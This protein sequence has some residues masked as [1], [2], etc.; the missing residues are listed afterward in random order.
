MRALMRPVSAVAASSPIET[1][2][3]FFSITT[4]AYFHVLSAIKYSPFFAPDAPLPPR[5]AHALLRDNEW[6]GVKHSTWRDAAA[7]PEGDVAALELQQ[8]V[9]SLDTNAAKR[10]TDKFSQDASMVHGSLANWTRYLTH[11]FPTTSGNVY[12]NLCYHPT[13]G[14]TPETSTPCFTSIFAESPKSD[15]LTL[16]FAPGARD[17]FMA[18]FKKE[19][20]FASEQFGSVKYVIEQAE[21]ES[22]EEMKSGKWMAYAA[23]T[24]VMRF[25]DLAKKAD[26][27]DIVLILAGYILMHTTFIK[28]FLASR[29][30]G[31]NLWLTTAILASSVLAFMVSLPIA[32]YL[33]IPLEPVSLIEALP[34]LV[35]T[36][37]FEKPLRL[38]RAVFGHSH[39]Y[40]PAVQEG[41]NRGQMK[42][43]PTIILEALDKTGNS[44]LRDY[45]L[46]I[47]VL[48]IGAYSR[49]GGLKE[50]CAL[51]AV[52]LFVDCVSMMTFYVAI[53]SVMIEVRRIKMFRAMRSGSAEA[54]SPTLVNGQVKMPELTFRQRLSAHVLG[55]KGSLLRQIQSKNKKDETDQEPE[56]PVARLKLLLIASFLTL[57]LLNLCTTL[58]PTSPLFRRDE[59]SSL[60]AP[61]EVAPGARKVDITSPAI[62]TVLSTLS[63][64]ENASGHEL[65]VCVPAP[66][67]VHMVPVAPQHAAKGQDTHG[68]DEFIENFMT[69]WT[70]LVGDPVLSK[71]I[72]VI[73]GISVALNGYLLKGISTGTGTARTVA[74]QSVRFTSQDKAV[75]PSAAPELNEQPRLERFIAPAV[76]P[77]AEAVAAAKCPRAGV[78]KGGGGARGHHAEEGAG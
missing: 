48:L 22:I 35:C 33:R 39:V 16:S 44:I 4:L 34:F 53:L 62:S 11:E 51:A 26:S 19:A 46:E 3:F 42:P 29:S 37:G 59:P 47:A 1:I 21:S 69:S 8:V 74:L 20:V 30:L 2:V 64:L 38:A 32:G 17:E 9:I 54:K 75:A 5:P 57:H 67:N 65:L 63:D 60:L 58:T 24:M 23:R 7:F 45:A 41:R 56:T 73:L 40:T 71:W 55:V 49:V 15:I 68:A 25:W 10:L 76:V 66:I 43:A 78:R 27:L 18:A 12:P 14:S 70:T 72:V 36:V 31:S 52:L 77:P 6:V 28:L 50:F 13:V 61:V